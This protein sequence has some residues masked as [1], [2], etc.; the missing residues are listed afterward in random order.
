M[1]ALAE[2]GLKQR[3]IHDFTFHLS[4]LENS[5]TMYKIMYPTDNLFGAKL[6]FRQN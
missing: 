4:W 2:Q 5:F 6:S 3:R 1:N